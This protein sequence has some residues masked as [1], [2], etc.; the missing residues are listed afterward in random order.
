MQPLN[1]G[2]CIKEKA[3]RCMLAYV[4]AF[5]Y[6]AFNAMPSAALLRGQD[7]RLPFMVKLEEFLACRKR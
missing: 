7:S 1:Q 3:D 6:T 5:S 2:I 4:A